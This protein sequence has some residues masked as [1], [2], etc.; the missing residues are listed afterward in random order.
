M[1]ISNVTLFAHAG[2]SADAANPKVQAD[3]A[4]RL[5]SADRKA[6][7]L[8]LT[9]VPPASSDTDAAPKEAVRST[10]ATAS[11]P[12]AAAEPKPASSGDWGDLLSKNKEQ[13]AKATVAFQAEIEK[14]KSGG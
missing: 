13:E 14:N 5:P 2:R 1:V 4:N 11:L 7:Q 10:D 12:A 3:K 8:P 6:E 9:L